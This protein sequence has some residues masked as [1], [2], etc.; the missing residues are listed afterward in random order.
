MTDNADTETE[1]YD[2]V[3][4]GELVKGVE[5]DVAKRNIGQL[6]KIDGAKV[7]KLFSGSATVL[8]KGLNFE[9]AS[10]YRVAIKKAGA[11]VDLK[12]CAAAPRVVAKAQFGP[13]EEE[14]ASMPV[15]AAPAGAQIGAQIESAAGTFSL[16]PAG[17]DLLKSNEKTLQE[18]VVVDTS[19][20][21]VRPQQGNLL[22][23][24]EYQQVAPPPL[25]LNGYDLAEVGTDVLRP[26]ERA[27]DVRADVDIS[28]LSLGPVGER[29]APEKAAP[30]PPP[31]VSGI[32]LV[33]E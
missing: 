26:D 4:R 5:L 7:E 31:D 29:L 22:D 23:D 27:P 1:T 14:H 6:F 32:H 20:M 2:L 19:A 13:T 24:G 28:G 10:R 21:S 33:G 11:R 16:A 8:K 9:A 18:P 25:D 3:F 12:P 30:P 17:S 15:V